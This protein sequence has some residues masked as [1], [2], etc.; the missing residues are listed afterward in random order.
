MEVIEVPV[1]AQLPE[2][3]GGAENPQ[4]F[5]D[6]VLTTL[7]RFDQAF[8]YAEHELSGSAVSSVSW[9]IHPQVAGITSREFEAGISPSETSFR[10]SLDYIRERYM[11]VSA[12]HGCAERLLRQGDITR[13]CLLFLPCSPQSGAWIRAYVSEC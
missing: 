4:V 2:L 1:V 11:G 3:S 13:R 9:R 8:L 10:A 5:V 7:L 6:M 12:R